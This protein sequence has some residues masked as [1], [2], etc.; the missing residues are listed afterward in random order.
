MDQI[1]GDRAA[2]GRPTDSAREFR[3]EILQEEQVLRPDVVA[4]SDAPPKSI[5]T[6]L[7]SWWADLITPDDEWVD[8]P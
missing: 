3:D 1:C 8:V 7:R 5:F 2:L 6:R 4:P